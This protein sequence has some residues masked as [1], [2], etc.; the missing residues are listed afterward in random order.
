M[1]GDPW[2]FNPGK[3]W[4]SIK[5]QTVFRRLFSWTD[6][7]HG[8]IFV[9]FLHYYFLATFLFLS[10]RFL[11]VRFMI[12]LAAH[13]AAAS[14][15]LGKNVLYKIFAWY[16]AFSC[17]ALVSS[18]DCLLTWVREKNEFGQLLRYNTEIPREWSMHGWSQWIHYLLNS[19]I[20]WRLLQHK[21][22][23]IYLNQIEKEV[24]SLYIIFTFNIAHVLLNFKHRL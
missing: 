7:Y 2:E 24:I 3:H 13:Q 16:F 20:F 18:K 22:E 5:R 1:D 21:N 6:Y 8:Y 11:S 15:F 12:R 23:T 10:V 17:I 14:S 19:K 4:H 9:I